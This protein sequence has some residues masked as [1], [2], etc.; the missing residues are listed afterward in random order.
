MY[1]HVC[2]HDVTIIWRLWNYD[3][4]TVRHLCKPDVTRLPHQTRSRDHSAS[5][6][7][8]A[9]LKFAFFP[10]VVHHVRRCSCMECPQYQWDNQKGPSSH[11]SSLWVVWRAVSSDHAVIDWRTEFSH[12]WTRHRLSLTLFTGN[13]LLLEVQVE[14]EALE[15]WYSNPVQRGDPA[16][17]ILD[18]LLTRPCVWAHNGSKQTFQ[19][20]WLRC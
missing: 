20:T 17:V 11:I 5:C 4:T 19:I 7:F 18:V 8:H 13:S 10:R 3:I 14:L 1:W 16:T 15:L 12:Q 9:S 6:S 2:K